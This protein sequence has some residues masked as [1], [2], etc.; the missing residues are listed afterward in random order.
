MEWY[1]SS[2]ASASTITINTG[3]AAI[4]ASDIQTAL[5]LETADNGSPLVVTVTS[6]DDTS[7]QTTFKIVFTNPVGDIPTLV[8]T[9]PASTEVVES[10][11]GVTPVTGSFT[12][13][14]EGQYTDDIAMDASAADMKSALE[15]LS[16]IGNLRVLRD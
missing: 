9:T 15:A 10:V 6:I 3:P 12:V 11:K 4:I 1:A 14:F 8:V 2:S 5:E 16:T 13:F 7:G